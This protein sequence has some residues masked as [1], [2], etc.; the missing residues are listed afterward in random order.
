MEVGE[1]GHV[2]VTGTVEPFLVLFR[3]EGAH[4][5][6]AACFVGEDA[7]D[8]RAALE[9]LVEAF[10]EVGAL[11]V[12]VVGVREAVEGEGL[13]DLFFDPRGEL[14]VFGGPALQPCGEVLAGFGAVAP[15]V[16]PAQFG[17]AVIGSL[18][19]Q[20]TLCVAQKVDVAA[21][22]CGLGKHLGDGP[23]EAGMGRFDTVSP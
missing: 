1:V 16:E 22:P 13:L 23:L 17:Q 5:A 15:V 2:E 20:M 4:E 7:D 6:Q 8:E 19:G 12:F 21:L 10:E 9:F 3:G 18:A 11:E 14:R